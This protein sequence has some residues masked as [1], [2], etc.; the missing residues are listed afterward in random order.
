MNPWTWN[1]PKLMDETA[2][3]SLATDKLLSTA[4][5]LGTWDIM[6]LEVI[7]DRICAEPAHGSDKV[8]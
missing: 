8:Y 4:S 3:L 1:I 6:R 2:N 7:I 5:K